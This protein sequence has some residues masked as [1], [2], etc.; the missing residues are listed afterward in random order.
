MKTKREVPAGGENGRWDLI[1]SKVHLV[2]PDDELQQ[3]KNL[4][5]WTNAQISGLC[6]MMA[7]D[8]TDQERDW[9][10]YSSIDCKI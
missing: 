4:E 2:Q 3:V 5:L 6:S 10:K 9:R 7:D 8:V 1:P